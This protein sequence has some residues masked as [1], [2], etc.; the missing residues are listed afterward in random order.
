MRK[1]EEAT[2]VPLECITPWRNDRPL[3]PHRESDSAQ[4]SKDRTRCGSCFN[5]TRRRDFGLLQVHKEKV[6]LWL[7]VQAFTFLSPNWTPGDFDVIF[8]PLCGRH[9]GIR[10]VDCSWP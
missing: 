7:E 8:V 3:K 9:N 10:N 1:I 5:A 6:S 2:D 4:H